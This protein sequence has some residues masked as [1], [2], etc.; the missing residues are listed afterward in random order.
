MLTGSPEGLVGNLLAVLGDEDRYRVAGSLQLAQESLAHGAMAVAQEEDLARR[1]G[2]AGVVNGAGE[3]HQ[4][5]VAA[6]LRADLGPGRRG[7][8]RGAGDDVADLSAEEASV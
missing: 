6:L 3:G 8:G 7:V 1:D 5:G 4:G 2:D